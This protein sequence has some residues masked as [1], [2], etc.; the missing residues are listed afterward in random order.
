MP[1]RNLAVE[2]ESA[3]RS[4]LKVHN[5]GE[6]APVVSEA[7]EVTGFISDGDIMR[8]L[9]GQIPAFKT[10]YSFVVELGNESFDQTI[11]EVASTSVRNVCMHHVIS[12]PLMDDLG[13][14]VQVLAES[15]VKKAP[16][17]ENGKM[18][19]IVNRSNITRYCIDRYLDSGR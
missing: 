16:V 4:L 12:I 18:V 2:K 17:V 6:G 14:V 19:S 11:R 10:T 8:C 5:S 15:H 3:C 7:N 9:S 13:A 1:S